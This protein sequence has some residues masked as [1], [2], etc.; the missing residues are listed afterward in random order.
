[1]D[2]EPESGEKAAEGAQGEK[3]S[4]RRTRVLKSAVATFHSGF[5]GVP[6]VVRNLSD[7]G[8]RVEFRDAAAIP[9]KFELHV[10]MDGFK[11]ECRRVWVAG[12]HC[13]VQFCSDRMPTRHFRS[14]T[15]KTSENAL[16]DFV[17]RDLAR[18]ERLAAESA[19]IQAAREAEERRV[20]ADTEISRP[21]PRLPA[22][23][24]FGQRR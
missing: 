15:L 2:G 21:A 1:M 18:R 8:A 24:S 10:E 4:S 13:G 22:G 17:K 23:L 5:S 9:E 16:S 12:R 3:R 11:V 14:Q 7:T 19:A 6:C 20:V